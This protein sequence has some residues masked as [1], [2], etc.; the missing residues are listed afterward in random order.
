V[1]E[2]GLKRYRYTG[3]EQDGETG[4]YYHGARYYAAWL[5]RWVS[6]DPIGIGDGLNLYIYVKNKPVKLI[7]DNGM[8]DSAPPQQS[9]W[10]R[11]KSFAGIAGSII[12]QQVTEVIT[13]PPGSPPIRD[14]SHFFE[15]RGHPA[16]QAFLAGQLGI[17]F[18][19]PTDTKGKKEWNRG[20]DVNKAIALA[21]LFGGAA[22]NLPPGGTKMQPALVSGGSPKVSAIPVPLT[23]VA[24]AF[25]A[26]PKK[27]DEKV[28][29]EHQN[30]EPQKRPALPSITKDPKI[31]RQQETKAQA[32]VRNKAEHQQLLAQGKEPTKITGK[33]EIHHIAS[34]KAEKNGWTAKLKILFDK[35]GINIKTAK[36][37]LV[38]VEGHGGSHGPDYNR[39]VYNRLLGAVT[40]KNTG[41][42]LTG[43]TYKD[44]LINELLSLKRDILTKGSMWNDLVT[45]K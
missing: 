39:L 16:R 21:G 44:A 5:G 30:S 2:V 6:A 28:S 42:L 41:Q 13:G 36:E 22:S 14:F 3:K 37:N 1:A 26:A 35:A 23:V 15:V 31:F 38:S 27:D 11:F 9:R 33:V 24:P 17:P 10:D 4:L 12:K 20:E 8:D 7:D 29:S 45:K 34:D 25:M 32:S 40:D 18:Q 19:E 43:Q